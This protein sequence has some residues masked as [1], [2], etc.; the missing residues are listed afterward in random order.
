MLHAL[1]IHLEQSTVFALAA[2]LLTLAFRRNRA[3]VRY[4]LWLSA[5]LKF[6]A[7]FAVLM[8][9]GRYVDMRAPSVRRFAAALPAASYTFEAI[10]PAE[11]P[12]GP[13]APTPINPIPGLIAGIWLTGLATI[14]LIRYRN[15]LRIRT[16]LRSSRGVTP[17]HVGQAFQPAAGFLPG[18][19]GCD[20]R[21][22]VW[23]DP[24]FSTLP[25]DFRPASVEVR[26]SPGLLEPGVIGIR[27]PVLLLPEGIA[28]RLKPS[29]LQAV[30][31]HE[32]CHIRRRDNLFAA[33][34]MLVEAVFWFHPL[35]W[36]IGAR[37][38]EE[39]ERACDEE[40]LSLGNQPEIYA[41]AILNVCKL[42]TESPLACVSGV[43]GSGIR[44]SGIRQ[45]IEA[46]MSDKKAH[47][48]NRAKKLLLA[49]AAAV[50]LAL[51]ILIGIGNAP[52]IQAQQPSPPAP[53]PRFDAASIR[54]CQAG[55]GPGRSAATWQP[56]TS[57]PV[58]PRESAATSAPLR[59]AWTSPAEAC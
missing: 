56:P 25:P 26:F 5:S 48:L 8:T 43:S 9:L 59:A 55:D 16:T 41:D 38:I 4:W 54:P 15:W 2:G 47:S 49:A 20:D 28:D 34:H 46:I 13:P 40:V 12:S 17:D 31:A 11:P 27:R 51:P 33:I 21:S 36:W 42:Y 7:P 29:E 24:G 50:A 14:A 22:G 58:C 52:A 53:R 23:R 37:L 10:S 44:H 19:P 57:T 39:R 1:A 30:L 35:V 3:Q 45:R 18:V 6:I 32:L